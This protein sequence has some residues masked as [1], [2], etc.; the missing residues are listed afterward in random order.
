[1]YDVHKKDKYQCLWCIE[2]DMHREGEMQ[3]EG[4]NRSSQQTHLSKIRL[5]PGYV[6]MGCRVGIHENI[7][8]SK[9]FH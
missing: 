4:C 7:N 2:V 5:D 1:M 9:T 3:S 6:D 8:T